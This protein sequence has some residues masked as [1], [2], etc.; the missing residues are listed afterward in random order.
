MHRREEWSPFRR[1]SAFGRVPAGIQNPAY[2]LPG[3]I[4]TGRG[5][6]G[7]EFDR[8]AGIALMD[9]NGAAALLGLEQATSRP[10][11]A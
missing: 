8:A 7:F 9:Q 3:I 10:F 4:L 5:S 11:E 1:R 2:R 6:D